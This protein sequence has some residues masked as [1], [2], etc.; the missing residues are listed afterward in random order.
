MGHEEAEEQ[1]RKEALTDTQRSN[2]KPGDIVTVR[3][4]AGCEADYVV[5]YAPWAL[6]HG[7]LVIGLKGISGGYSLDRV[8]KIVRLAEGTKCQPT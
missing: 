3:D 1:E 2:L 6:G 8:V 5:K 7:T 4:D